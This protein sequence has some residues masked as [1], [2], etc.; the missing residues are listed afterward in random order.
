MTTPLCTMGQGG[1]TRTALACVRATGAGS[2]P[3][4]P[5]V[6]G[7]EEDGSAAAVS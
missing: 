3:V 2:A 1:A 6:T 7:R 5:V 4:R